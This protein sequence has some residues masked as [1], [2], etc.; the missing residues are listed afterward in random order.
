MS[1]RELSQEAQE[2]LAAPEIF[3]AEYEISTRAEHLL[4]I[5]V[6]TLVS[7][8]TA[9][10]LRLERWPFP[11]A[12]IGFLFFYPLLPYFL[13][14]RPGLRMK[15]QHALGLTEKGIYMRSGWLN[16]AVLWEQVEAV[17]IS[18]SG[19][20]GVADIPLPPSSV[21]QMTA[22]GSV[23]YHPVLKEFLV[24]LADGKRTLPGQPKV[25]FDDHPRF[26]PSPQ[27]PNE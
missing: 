6:L 16:Y 12:W 5:A 4:A 8:I 23:P 15:R 9:G 10:I 25:L 7:I 14:F 20:F 24:E 27:E 26:L 1:Q 19:R 3:R 18:Q 2:I 11:G 21:I 17:G 22:L 13:W